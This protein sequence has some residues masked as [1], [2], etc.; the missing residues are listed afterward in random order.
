MKIIERHEPNNPT[1]RINCRECVSL[2]EVQQND[3]TFGT[4]RNDR[5]VTFKCPVCGYQPY[6]DLAVLPS[7]R[8]HAPNGPGAE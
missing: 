3:L 6:I 2:I 5:Y 4:D 7:Y 8:Y 1:Y